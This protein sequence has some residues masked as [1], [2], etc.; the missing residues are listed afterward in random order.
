[1]KPPSKSDAVRIIEVSPRDGLQNIPHQIPT[2][3][4]V[5]LIS[6][7][8]RTG[9]H[10]IELTS[11]VSP[12]AV[13]QLADCREVLGSDVVRDLQRRGLED[14]EVRRGR[15][16][17]GLLRL[18]VLVPNVKGLEMALAHGVREVAVFVSATEGFSRANI[19]CSV[20]E[21]L[22]RAVEVA[23]IAKEKGIAVRG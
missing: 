8:S 14:D 9:V 18:P 10:S 20:D 12:R 17:E 13:P 4:K 6:R 23:R 3:T 11:I 7:L 15:E 2:S 16:D 19:N 21:G 22:E 5:E 1:M